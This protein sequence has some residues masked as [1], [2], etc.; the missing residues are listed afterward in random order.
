MVIVVAIIWISILLFLTFR[1]FTFANQSSHENYKKKYFL[2]WA[3]LLVHIIALLAF[4]AFI[5]SLP[6]PGIVNSI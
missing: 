2:L 3:A 6:E 4:I 5:L 1:I